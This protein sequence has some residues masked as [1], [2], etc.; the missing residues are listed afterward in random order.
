MQTDERLRASLKIASV[1]DIRE[2]LEVHVMELQD[3]G[4]SPSSIRRYVNSALKATEHD[5][6]RSTVFL[7]GY[8]KR[9]RG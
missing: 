4:L 2:T 6:Y 9:E 7:R 5:G 8:W 1:D 3:L